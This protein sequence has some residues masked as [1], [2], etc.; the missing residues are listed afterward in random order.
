MAYSTLGF[1]IDHCGLT[2]CVVVFGIM[3]LRSAWY[4]NSCELVMQ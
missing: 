1:F 4:S 2:G 3:K